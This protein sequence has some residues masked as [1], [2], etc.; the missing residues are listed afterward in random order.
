MNLM[1][2][3][4]LPCLLLSLALTMLLTSPALAGGQLERVAFNGFAP[5]PV[6]GSFAADLVPIK[7]DT[8]CIPVDYVFNT[9]VLPANAEPPLD[10]PTTRAIFNDA[11]DTWNN[12]PT[13]FI[14]MGIR[15][16]ITR[17]RVAAFDV[18][19]FDFVN[20]VNFLLVPAD[21]GIAFSPS[22]S[23]TDSGDL[24]AGTDIDGD[25]DAD[26]FDPAVEGIE[27][28]SDVD[29]DG[30]IEFPAGFYEA[31]TILDNDI[32]FN[33]ALVVWT[34]G[35]PDR[36][37]GKL[38]LQGV[39]THE[40]GHSHGLSHSAI[41]QFSA[42]DGST[43]TMIPGVPTTD[44]VGE[45][46]L[47][48]LSSDDLAWTSFVYPE[49]S[50]TS[51][52]GALQPGDVAFGDVY[53]VITGEVTHGEQERPLAGG[54]IFAIDRDTGEVVA[55]HY[56]GN[57]RYVYT[58]DPVFLG[59]LPEFPEFHL[60]NG[61]YTLPLPAGDYY[62]AIEALDGTPV[63]SNAISGTTVV[64]GIFGQQN[65]N[66]EFLLRPGQGNLKPK[67]FKVKAGKVLSGVD[68]TTSIDINLDSFDTVGFN[69][70]VDYDGFAAINGPPHR[71]YALRFPAAELLAEL[72]AGFFPKAAAFRNFV[73][74]ASATV[75]LFERAALVAGSLNGTEATLDLED[76][77]FEVEEFLGQDNDFSP[78]FFEQPRNLAK[79]IEKAI[80]HDGVS[81]FFLILELPSSFSGALGYAPLI[82]F[83]IG[84]EVGL[85]GRSYLSDDGGD[86]F[87]EVPVN[88]MF[89]LI[90]GQIGNNG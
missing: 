54:H 27:V 84:Q 5:G 36:V 49:G 65:F 46:E 67:K 26:V 10:I 70:F 53:G 43:P 83:D 24:P 35:P 28:C 17:P 44:D 16:E 66:E 47:R 20:E 3:R 59:V 13:S 11:F 88:F 8:R 34:T 72:E 60:V 7:W 48:S 12:V 68:H 19:L 87:L 56:T 4:T 9:A 39:A 76:P 25:G 69:P 64:G 79:K 37:F 75:P 51:G 71:I 42:T 15:S 90:F 2:H 62:L 57:T 74:E 18:T 6:P 73:V 78:L 33:S 45:L 86:T 31:G 41:N 21:G 22:V 85:S 81:E 55:S 40:F 89:R 23:L 61:S 1:K 52:P 82:G 30:D 58:P 80:S 14:D 38:D 63:G 32:S 29:G 77:L 50:T